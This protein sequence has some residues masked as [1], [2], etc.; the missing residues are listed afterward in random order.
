MSKTAAFKGGGG[1]IFKTF[2]KGGKPYMG[3]LSIL[4]GDLITS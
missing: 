3:G 4:W 2:E 1:G